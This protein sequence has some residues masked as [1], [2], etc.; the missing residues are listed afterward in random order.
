MDSIW[1]HPYLR[2]ERIPIETLP[3][4]AVDLVAN[5]S[6]TGAKLIPSFIAP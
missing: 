2:P 5:C 1:G 4:G 6:P 3:G